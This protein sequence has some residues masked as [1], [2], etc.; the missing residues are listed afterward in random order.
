MDLSK[1]ESTG[2]P[3]VEKPS[4]TNNERGKLNYRRYKNVYR[5]E[6]PSCK[7][8]TY[9]H[10]IMVAH[11][12]TF[13]HKTFRDNLGYKFDYIQYKKVYPLDQQAEEEGLQVTM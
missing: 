13:K 6:C 5:Y 2:S 4:M 1:D 9:F 8:R 3:N 12:E 10:N 11:I 7:K